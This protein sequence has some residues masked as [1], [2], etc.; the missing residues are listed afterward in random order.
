MKDTLEKWKESK[1]NEKEEF[2]QLHV[3]INKMNDRIEKL[4]SVNESLI[5]KIKEKE[6]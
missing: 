2:S 5:T 4:E 1:R 6:E 3:Q